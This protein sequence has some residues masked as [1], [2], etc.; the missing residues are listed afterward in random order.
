MDNVGQTTEPAPSSR[1][2]SAESQ[3]NADAPGAAQDVQNLVAQPMSKSAMKKAAKAER[4][5]ALKLERRSREKE[6]KKEK[7]RLLAEK[8][9]AGEIDE[10]EEEERRRR[11]KRPRLQFGG[12]VVVDLGFDSLMS[13][14]EVVSLCSQLA[15]TYST[16][17][18]ASFPFGLTFTS[19][20]G[21]TEKR[22]DSLGDASHRRW[23]NTKWSLD[24]YESLW[25]DPEASPASMYDNTPQA[26]A[27]PSNGIEGHEKVEA[28][29]GASAGVEEDPGDQS[30]RNC[31]Q[32]GSFVYLTADTEDELL[33]LKPDETYIIGG[34]VDHNRHKNLCLN[35][36]KESGIRTARLPIGLYLSSLPTR[37]VLTVNQV[38]EILV[39]WVETKDWEQAFNSI[40]PKRKFQHGGKGNDE[41]IIDASA[42]ECATDDMP[43]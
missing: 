37:K 14:K 1:D 31:P 19:L 36:A 30:V 40:I 22:L 29:E 26:E 41:A 39:K 11:A 24:S 16:N 13:D 4:L 10:A 25:E 9:A 34:I 23:S 7:K 15:Y 32:K 6:A 28:S 8:R 33:E 35:K 38:F 17:R 42:V 3:N 27:C 18:Q 43:S 20:S 2:L 5:A 12:N 21:R